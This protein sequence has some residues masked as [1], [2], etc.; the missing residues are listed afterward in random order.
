MSISF[1]QQ[2][3]NWSP[4]K[5]IKYPKT[6]GESTWESKEQL[7]NQILQEISEKY[8]YANLKKYIRCSVFDPDYFLLF[9]TVFL[10]YQAN[11]YQRNLWN[12]LSVRKL[13]QTSITQ[14]LRQKLLSVNTVCV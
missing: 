3:D 6:A 2:N 14:I 9:C 13:R 5:I 11:F 8:S 12:K 7:N 4:A 1:F 10:D